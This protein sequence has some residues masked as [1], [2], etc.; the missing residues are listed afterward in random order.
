MPDLSTEQVIT[1]LSILGNYLS[2]PSAEL[3]QLVNAAQF[4]NAWFTAESTQN[5]LFSIG[6]SLKEEKLKKWLLTYESGLFLQ[7]KSKKVG[8][9]LAGNL[10]LVGF[11]DIVCVLASGNK[12]LIK[13]SSQDTKLIPFLLKK[14]TEIEPAF[15]GRFEFVERLTDF[16]AIIA[17]GS[18]NSSRYFDYYFSKYP[19]IIR[20]NRNSVAVLN[21]SETADDFHELG[22]DIFWYF[23]LGCRNVSKLYVPQGY[24]FTSFFEGIESYK[25]IINH[26]KYANNFDYN[27][28]LL[29]MNKVKYLENHFLMISENSSYSSPIAS[30]H[31]EFYAD[32]TELKTRLATD[33]DLIQCV[34]SKD[35]L[36]QGSL[37]FGTA[38]QP[39][40]WDYADGIDTMEFLLKI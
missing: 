14:L 38:Q 28:T 40:L 22:K 29:L 33:A 37:S 36:F 35:G 11:H 10:P 31:Y 4:N 5:A 26:N 25:P 6:N 12:A 39:E 18:N 24:N 3:E 9:I 1:S 15:A 34:V 19:H 7:K 16:D 23:G 27:L 13:L 17:T 32:E 21:G 2:N 30:L 8:L 20:K